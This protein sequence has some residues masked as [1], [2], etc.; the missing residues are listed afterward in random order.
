MNIQ[1]L[2]E[3]PYAWAILSICTIVALIFAVYTWIV[4][5]KKMELSCF[6][7]TLWVVKAG[8]SVIP[9][10][11]LSYEGQAIDDLT[12][13]KYVIWNSGNEVLNRSDI[14]RVC[15]LQIVSDG[16]AQIL[17]AQIIV[18][19]DV[20]NAFKILEKKDKCV[21]LEFDYANVGDGI[22]LQILHTGDIADINVECK[23]KGGNKLR[24]LNHNIKKKNRNYN[25][26][27]RLLIILMGVDVLMVCVMSVFFVLG[28]VGIIAKETLQEIIFFDGV[29]NDTFF[30]MMLLILVGVVLIK[31]V[32]LVKKVFYIGIPA[33]LRKNIEWNN[34]GNTLATENQSVKIN[35][36]NKVN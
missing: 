32:R 6:Y 5:K 22:I 9:K 13:T 1:E 35:Y 11:S 36:V 12:V 29:I 31:Y 14:V 19:S 3:N 4:G 20:T 30:I 8:K 2:M 16:N 7:N 23:I 17:D 24:N 21:K 34:F 33:K 28:R 18:Q 10:L 27:K 25:I 26:N 15:P